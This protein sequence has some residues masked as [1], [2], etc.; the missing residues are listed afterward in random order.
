MVIRFWVG[1]LAQKRLT[2]ANFLKPGRRQ[3]DLGFWASEFLNRHQPPVAA[4]C[5]SLQTL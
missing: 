5:G 3:I 1:T 2:N 4:Q